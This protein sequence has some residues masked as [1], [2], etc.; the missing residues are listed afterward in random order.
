M[1]IGVAGIGRMG[2]AIAA[3][4]IDVGHQVT[5][6]NRSVDKTKP[7]AEAGAYVAPTPAA[8]VKEVD[9]VITILTDAAALDRVFSGPDGLLSLDVAGKLFIEMSTVSPSTSKNLAEAVRSK[10]AVFVECPVGGTV[11]RRGKGNC[12]DS[13]APKQ[14]T[15]R[16]PGQSSINSASGSSISARSA[17]AR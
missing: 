6:W 7:L 4:L 2:G 3:H 10:G 9:C 13:S 11:V 8:L 15:R 1:K 17:Q 16:A 12:W 14:T 5:V